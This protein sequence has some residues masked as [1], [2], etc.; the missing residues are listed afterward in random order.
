MNSFWTKKYRM[1]EENNKRDR[2]IVVRGTPTLQTAVGRDCTVGIG[3]I[4][5][6]LVTNKSCGSN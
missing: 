1:A 5:L 3:A 4:D 2:G 6:S